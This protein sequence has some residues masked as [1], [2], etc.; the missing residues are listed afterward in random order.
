MFVE[1]LAIVGV[2]LIGGSFAAALRA[3][4]C[5]GSVVGIDRDPVNLDHARSL[6]LIDSGSDSPGAVAGAS[7]VLVAV[8]V[9]A[10]RD[11]LSRVAGHLGA[12]AVISDVGSAKSQVVAA[13][14]Q[15]L[16]AAFSRFVPGHPVAGSDA[17]GAAAASPSLFRGR[18][19]VLAPVEQTDAAA[20]ELMDAAWRACGAVVSR[21]SPDIHDR[22]LAAVSH[23]PH[24][25]AYAL[26]DRIA[27]DADPERLLAHAAGGFRD[28]TRIAAS[29]PDI[30]RDVCLANGPALLAEIGLYRD[31]LDR[32]AGMIERGDAAALDAL[33]G[34]ARDLRRGWKEIQAEPDAPGRDAA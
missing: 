21:L 24:V 34:R 4:G 6:G 12:A 25:L 13:A 16:G 22:V 28:V 33:F 19:V 20:V 14:R 8:P 30:W 1:R 3:A 27:G 5:V 10:I 18:R 15:T 23:L 9:M 29:H 17:S 2:G 31:A 32:I 7:L 11:T 26:V